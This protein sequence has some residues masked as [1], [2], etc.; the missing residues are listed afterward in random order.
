MVM[1]YSPN[2]VHPSIGQRN[3]PT[4]SYWWTTTILYVHFVA[5]RITLNV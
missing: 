4:R 1:V 2:M 5:F 3:T